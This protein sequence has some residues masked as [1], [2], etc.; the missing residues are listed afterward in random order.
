MRMKM[1]VATML[2][3]GFTPE[4]VET[5]VKHNPCRMLDV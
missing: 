5:M 1:A 3:A 2:K 4:D